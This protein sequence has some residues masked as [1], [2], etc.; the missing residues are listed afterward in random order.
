MHRGLTRICQLLILLESAKN[1]MES[2]Y[3]LFLEDE[4]I[5]STCSNREPGSLNVS[6]MFDYTNTT[7]AM[8][9]KGVTISGNNT[10]VWDIQ[11]TDRVQMQSS[12]WFFERGIWQPTTLSLFVFDFCKV[13]FDSNQ[14]WYKDYTRH[15][16]NTAEVK[17]TCLRVKGTIIQLETYRVDFV[18][19][20]VYPLRDGRYALRYIFT[21]YDKNEVRRPNVICFEIKGEF[22]KLRSR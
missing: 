3:E 2:K 7:F 9:E 14:L 5:I 12:L 18:I 15:I 6:S 19:S 21:A 17:E 4:E 20:S 10:V 8:D 13:M 1:S 11:P 16:A 22:T